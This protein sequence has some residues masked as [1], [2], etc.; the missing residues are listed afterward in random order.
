M[1]GLNAV[2]GQVSSVIVTAGIASA[3]VTDSLIKVSH[4]ARTRR[5][6]LSNGSMF[7]YLTME[8]VQEIP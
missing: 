1:H 2:G 7:I 8:S 5:V 6:Q 3:G 4:I